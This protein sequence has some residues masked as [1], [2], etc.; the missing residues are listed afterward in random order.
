MTGGSRGTPVPEQEFRSIDD[1]LSYF[2]MTLSICSV[3]SITPTLP[4]IQH[5]K[6]TL[7]FMVLNIQINNVHFHP[8]PR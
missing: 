8:P 6:L 3:E 7:L 2:T 1:L 5:R 4:P